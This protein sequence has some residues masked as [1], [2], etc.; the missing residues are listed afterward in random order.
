MDHRMRDLDA[1]RPAVD[2]QTTRFALENRHEWRGELR[3]VIRQ[4]QCRGELAFQVL[5]HLLQ[6]R[7][8]RAAN[9]D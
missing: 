9:H 6:L 5:E 1:S 3:V 7:L 4:M 2:D 8:A